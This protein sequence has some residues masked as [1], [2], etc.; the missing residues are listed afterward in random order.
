MTPLPEWLIRESYLAQIVGFLLISYAWVR[1]AQ[2]L[3]RGGEVP[4]TRMI[5]FVITSAAFLATFIPMALGICYFVPGCF[6]PGFRDILRVASGNII[7][8][9]GLFKAILYATKE[10]E[11]KIEHVVRKRP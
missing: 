8:I 6:Q 11:P 3:I 9:Y 10:K 2:E 4:R 7:L 5:M 1:S